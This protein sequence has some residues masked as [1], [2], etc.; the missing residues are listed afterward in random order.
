MGVKKAGP[1][2]E[3]KVR[4]DWREKIDRGIYR[5]HSSKCPSR[6]R[7]GLRCGCPYA[8]AAPGHDGRT[9]LHKVDGTLT[10]ARKERARLQSIVGTVAAPVRD[11]EETLFEF[12]ARWLLLRRVDLRPATLLIYERQYRM[13]IHPHLGDLRLAELTRRRLQEWV[14]LLIR[15]DDSRRQVELAVETLRSMLSHAVQESLL[16]HNPLFGIKLPRPPIAKRR[17]ETVLTREQSEMLITH[18]G[19]LRNETMLRVMLEAGLRRGEVIG[20]RWPQVDIKRKRITVDR[21]IWQAANG[22][23]IEHTPKNG[24]TH[25]A[26]ITEDLA[27]RLAAWLQSSVVD[28]GADADG[29]VWPGP[30]GRALTVTTVS[31]AVSKAQKRAGLLGSDGKPLVSPHGLRHTAAS[32]ALEDNVSLF[33]VSR[34]LGHSSQIVTAQRYSHL[35][36]DHQLDAFAE[37]Q[38]NGML[39]GKLRDLESERKK[40][41]ICR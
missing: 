33:V 28:A 18:A 32:T 16:E 36:G 22:E 21:S 11:D 35:L 13:R 27:S 39:R 6:G 15:T 25:V 31:R 26:A 41:S 30:T 9:T 29:F 8:V 19:S 37:A 10:A 5:N 14:A 38:G 34:Q 12:A 2:G 7:A 4:H 40:G 24:R 20:L 1:S 17:A 3:K 23:R